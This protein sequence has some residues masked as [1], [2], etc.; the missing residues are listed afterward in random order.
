MVKKNRENMASSID[1][2]HAGRAGMLLVSMLLASMLLADML[3]AGMLLAG[4]LLEGMLLAG[5]LLVGMRAVHACAIRCTG[6][7]AHS[8]LADNTALV[9]VTFMHSARVNFVSHYNEL[10]G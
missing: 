10:C 2:H 3:L 5:M 1:S 7:D 9:C 6:D 8:Y 4:M